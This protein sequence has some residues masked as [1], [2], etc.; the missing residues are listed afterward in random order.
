MSMTRR[1]FIR[2]TQAAGL[3]FSTAS[4]NNLAAAYTSNAGLKLVPDTDRL[5]DL[6]KGFSYTVVSVT[7]EP[8][9]DGFLR[10]GR[11]DGMACFPHPQESHKCILLRN[12]ENWPD[13]VEGSPFGTDNALLG[14]VPAGKLYDR[15]ANGQPFIGG[16]TKVVY[17][18]R[19]KKLE[20]D[21]LVLT[22]TA[23]NCAGGPTPWGS[24]LSCEESAVTPKD[25]AGKTH[26]W[27]FEV[28]ASAT[29]LVDPVPLKAMGRF[30][31]EATAVDPASGI[32]YLTEDNRT[33][34]FYRFMPTVKGELAKGGRLQALVIKEWPSAD[35]RNWPHDWGGAGFGTI[36]TG[37]V[38]DVEWIDVED[39]EA[40]DGDLAARGHAAGAARF[41]RGEGVA[42]AAQGDGGDVYFNCT[43]G[44][45]QRVGQIW[46]YSPAG[47][48][49]QLVYESSGADV[50]DNCDNLA[51][52]PWGDLVICED[53]FGEQYMRG[54][55]PDGTLY[56]LARN[57]HSQKSEF[58]GACFSPDGSV[59][60]VNIQEPGITLAITGPWDSLRSKSA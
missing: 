27:V 12:H 42:W 16:V 2:Y 49:V 51:V 56:D 25:G 30:A 13:T 8:M 57:A 43:Q 15:K 26:G 48:Q 60:F 38:M 17:D 1:D 59:L 23:G 35:T 5:L 40:P 10:P 41:C 46:R 53:G 37:K 6:P 54:L 32:V 20:E 36:E 44:G 3:F 24:W 58:C 9:A 7:G 29:G 28:P 50:L 45:A 14:R 33:G 31:H 21:Y 4:F 52:A 47:Q 19:N 39:V 22:G 34:L 11:P 18:L 55:R